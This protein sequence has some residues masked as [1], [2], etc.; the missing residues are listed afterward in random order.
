VTDLNILTVKDQKWMRSCEAHARTF[1]TC[2]KRQYAA[3][4]VDRHGALIGSGYNGGPSGMLHCNDG[5]CPRAINNVPGGTPYD[6]GPGLCIA[7]HAEANALLHSDYTAR[8]HGGTLYVNGP[9]CM[10]CAKLVANSGLGRIV[11]GRRACPLR[12]RRLLTQPHT[13]EWKRA[14]TPPVAVAVTVTVTCSPASVQHSA[15]W[16]A[17]THASTPQVAV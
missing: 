5:G 4:I 11:C 10:G 9:P 2:S 6:Y 16:R 17:N 15:M 13:S 14:A 8:R 12:R 1:S 3:L 7:I